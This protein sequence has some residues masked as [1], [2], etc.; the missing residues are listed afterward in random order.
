MLDPHPPKEIFYL[1]QWKPFKNDEKCFLFHLKSSFCFQDIS[2][3]VLTFWLF[4]KNGLIRK[5]RL[6]PKFMTSQPGYQT[7]T[8]HILPYIS[9]SKGNQTMTFGQLIE[10]NKRNIFLQKSCRK[11]DRH[12]SSRLLFFLKNAL[13][14]VKA[15][16]LLLNF[17]IFR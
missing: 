9:E 13:Y 1:L 8:I 11:W 5:I 4:R 14:E 3:F 16:D 12:T 7:L 17:D 6:V 10:Y 2:S 15:S